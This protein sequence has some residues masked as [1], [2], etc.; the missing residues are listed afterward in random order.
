RSR[1]PTGT[2]LPHPGVQVQRSGAMQ[3]DLDPSLDV[4][5][6]GERIARTHH[7]SVQVEPDA[8]DVVV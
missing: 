6:D 5:L 7:L 1:L 3:L 8:L 2:H 4:W